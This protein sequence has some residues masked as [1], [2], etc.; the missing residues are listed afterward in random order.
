MALTNRYDEFYS[1]LWRMRIGAAS[2]ARRRARPNRRAGHLPD[3]ALTVAL[4]CTARRGA[5]PCSLLLKKPRTVAK[6]HGSAWL[7]YN[8]ALKSRVTGDKS[9]SV[10]G[11][12]PAPC[13]MCAEFAQW[14]TWG[15]KFIFFWLNML[16]CQICFVFLSR[17]SYS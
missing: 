2:P 4:L 14:A 16:T 15:R 11:H 7:A 8:K 6:R 9:F 10:L 3:V 5:W 1:L 13:L 17:H 12:R